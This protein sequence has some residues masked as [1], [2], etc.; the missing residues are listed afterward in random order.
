MQ[1]IHEPAPAVT[2]ATIGKIEPINPNNHHPATTTYPASI[3]N[4][5]MVENAG[6]KR[7]A[8][9]VHSN[10]NNAAS[11]Q[12]VHDGAGRTRRPVKAI[13]ATTAWTTTPGVSLPSGVG[14]ESAVA[15]VAVMPMN[16]S[17]SRS[18]TFL[19]SYSAIRWVPLTIASSSK[20][21][22]W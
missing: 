20:R 5:N 12:P 7:A 14:T 8:N 9:D 6:V 17:L 21:Q 1:T 19:F 2:G 16:T 22:C 4:T 18:S 10:P 15:A 13:S 11:A 3:T